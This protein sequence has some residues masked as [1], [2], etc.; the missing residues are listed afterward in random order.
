MARDGGV[1]NVGQAELAEGAAL[2]FLGAIGELAHRQEAVEREF[3]NFFAE[4]FGFERAADQ[5][6]AAAEHGDFGAGES[7][8]GEQALLGRGALAAQ[9]AALAN[10]QRLAEL[11]FH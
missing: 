10:R 2:F 6:G 9:T 8:I 11:G 3:E 7:G 1:G 4:D 5:R